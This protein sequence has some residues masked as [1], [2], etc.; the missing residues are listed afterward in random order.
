MI[1]GNPRS[2]EPEL[3]DRAH[4]KPYTRNHNDN[5]NPKYWTPGLLDV[6]GHRSMDILKIDIWGGE[7]DTLTTSIAANT[8]RDMLTIG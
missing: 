6:N 1:S 8:E 7:F 4:F 3:G 2:N 5:G